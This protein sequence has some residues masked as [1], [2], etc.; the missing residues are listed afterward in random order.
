MST[1]AEGCAWCA[2]TSILGNLRSRG[3]QTVALSLAF[4]ISILR[5]KDDFRKVFM[6]AHLCTKGNFLSF[7]VSLYDL[8]PSRWRE[9]G[10]SGVYVPAMPVAHNTTV[11]E[12]NSGWPMWNTY[13]ITIISLWVTNFGMHL[14]RVVWLVSWVCIA[15]GGLDS[16]EHCVLSIIR[17]IWVGIFWPYQP[18]LLW[19][20][21][22]FGSSEEIKEQRRF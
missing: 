18:L 15:R 13:Q 6:S 17:G 5:L 3:S 22:A 4:H 12:H 10:Q 7:W 21:F 11:Q 1:W 20:L 8:G 14:I 9:G 19:I 2:Q 16:G